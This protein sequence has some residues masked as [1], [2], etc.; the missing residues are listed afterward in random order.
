MGQL[1]VWMNGELVGTWSNDNSHTFHYAES[2]LAGEHARPLSLSMPLTH[3]LRLRGPTVESYFDNLLPDNVD[4][5]RRIRARFGARSTGAFELLEAIGRDCVGAAQLLPIGEVP[6]DI[7][8]VEYETL[9]DADV[10]RRLRDVIVTPAFGAQG[11]LADFRISIAGAQEK[12][13]LLRLDGNWCRPLGSTPTT[14]IIKLPLGRVTRYQADFTT[15]V[16]NEWLCAQ[17]AR[18]LGL[19]VPETTIAQFGARRALVVKRFDRDWVEDDPTLPHGYLIRLP[20]E[21]MCQATGTLASHKYEN[22]GGPGMQQCLDILGNS[23]YPS[24]ARLHFSLSQLAF[25]LLAA[26]D[27]H[28]K[29][30]SLFINRGGTYS[31]TPLYD[32][33]SAWPVIGRGANQ[34]PYQEA[35]LAMALRSKNVHYKLAEIEPRHWHQLAMRTGGDAVW[36][37]MRGMVEQVDAALERVERLLPARFPPQVWESIK[38]GMQRHAGKFLR[39]AAAIQGT[40]A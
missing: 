8:R 11:D 21:D 1:A 29:N 3:G 27:G 7:R 23:E 40:A 16:E 37:A 17:I 28:A 26:T 13:A 39:G 24:E 20:Q 2:W 36:T 35:G 33:L 15:S 25:W 9:T 10:E 22:E 5:R 30:F 12:T 34:L 6:A 32:I 14:H 18:E 19:D 38:A 4:I 31:P